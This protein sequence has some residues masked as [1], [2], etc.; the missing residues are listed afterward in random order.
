[1]PKVQLYIIN[2]GKTFFKRFSLNH[3]PSCFLQSLLLICLLPFYP[4]AYCPFALDYLPIV[5]LPIA[6][7]PIIIPGNEN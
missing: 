5:L 2:A 7:L 4:F 3:G 6:H 1:M